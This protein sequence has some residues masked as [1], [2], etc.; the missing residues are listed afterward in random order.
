MN[1]LDEQV[2]VIREVVPVEAV[3]PLPYTWSLWRR[4]VAWLV[5]KC[6][7]VRSIG[8][9]AA[10]RGYRNPYTALVAVT[11]ARLPASVNAS[12]DDAR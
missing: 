7:V 4:S 2:D 10:G 6:P 9:M 3:V 11:A 12:E 8:R 1:P 5:W